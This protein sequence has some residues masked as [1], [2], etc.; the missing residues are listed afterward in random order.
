[1]NA[2]LLVNFID[3][4]KETDFNNKYN[5][6]VAFI[7]PSPVDFVVVNKNNNNNENKN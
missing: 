7:N 5:L 3:V 6:F 1:M 2:Y 4:Q